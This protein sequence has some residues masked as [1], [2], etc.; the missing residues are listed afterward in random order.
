M[1]KLH[2]DGIAEEVGASFSKY[3]DLIIKCV[4]AFNHC[5]IEYKSTDS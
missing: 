1:F 4:L 5:R 3:Y 2:I